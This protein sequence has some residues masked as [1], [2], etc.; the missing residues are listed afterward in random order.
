MF[1]FSRESKGQGQTTSMT[2]EVRRGI[3]SWVMN[4]RDISIVQMRKERIL[5]KLASTQ[6]P[7]SQGQCLRSHIAM[8]YRNITRI[9]K[10]WT[11]DGLSSS[12]EK[13]W[14][15]DKRV[16][17]SVNFTRIELNCCINS[18]SRRELL[19]LLCMAL[20]TWVI[21]WT[22]DGH[23]VWKARWLGP[24]RGKWPSGL[25]WGQP[26]ALLSPAS[27]VICSQSI[28]N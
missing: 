28:K 5:A 19:D 18:G 13:S 16:E 3:N 25:N 11:L 26:Y 8:N 10:L 24:R 12:W 14:V 4:R 6:S 17:K 2:Q 15:Q 9:I 7:R 20:W 27:I 1:F 21:G 22:V 23:C